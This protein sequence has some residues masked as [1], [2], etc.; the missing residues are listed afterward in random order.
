MLWSMVD[1]QRPLET[2][3]GEGWSFCLSHGQ[4]SLYDVADYTENAKVSNRMNV[5]AGVSVGKVSIAWNGTIDIILIP[6]HTSTLLFFIRK[7]PIGSCWPYVTCSVQSHNIA[8][9]V[10]RLAFNKAKQMNNINNGQRKGGRFDEENDNG[11][12]WLFHIRSSWPRSKKRRS[13]WPLAWFFSVFP[14]I[15]KKNRLH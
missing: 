2:L 7:Q 9:V 3:G 12:F 6:V 5:S 10:L 14:N 1:I 8:L 4:T 13:R 11:Q 15:K